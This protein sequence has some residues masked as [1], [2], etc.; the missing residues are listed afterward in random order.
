LSLGW[1]RLG[2][3]QALLPDRWEAS[4]S[5]ILSSFGVSLVAAIAGG[6]LCAVLGRS[7]RAPSI[8]AALVLLVGVVLAGV[9]LLAPSPP[10]VCGADVTLLEAIRHTKEPRWLVG[11]M[12]FVAATGVLIGALRR[13]RGQAPEAPPTAPTSS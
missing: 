13:L 3:D 6:F 8:L 9:I 11:A 4:P 12:P 2:A 10:S 5:W 7:M 1:S